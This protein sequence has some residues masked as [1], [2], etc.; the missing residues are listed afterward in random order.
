MTT[1]KNPQQAFDQLV[2]AIG[3]EIKTTREAIRSLDERALNQGLQPLGPGDREYMDRRRAQL[4]QVL[5]VLRGL[6]DTAEA[7]ERRN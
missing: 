1:M 5:N 2:H 4:V 7:I 6:Q 3:S